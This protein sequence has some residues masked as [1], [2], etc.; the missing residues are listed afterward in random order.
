M[1][2]VY[3][4]T[5]VCKLRPLD[6]TSSKTEAPDS[7]VKSEDDNDVAPRPTVLEENYLSTPSSELSSLTSE[8][9][10]TTQSN[11]G[12]TQEDKLLRDIF[13]DY[14]TPAQA[15]DEARTDLIKLTGIQDQLSHLPRA[16]PGTKSCSPVTTTSSVLSSPCS[17]RRLPVYQAP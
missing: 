17:R 5:T 15:L 4:N 16:R 7:T 2:T 3:G 8:L 1:R 9:P 10:R 6:K 14:N 13:E 12:E 11:H